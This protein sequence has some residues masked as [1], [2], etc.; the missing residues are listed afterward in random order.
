MKRGNKRK[1]LYYRLCQNGISVRIYLSFVF[2]L[3][4]TLVMT[5]LIFNQMYQKNYINSHTELLTK[6]GKK[7]A[8]RVAKF[9]ANDKLTQYEKYNVYLDELEKADKTDV[10]IV[11]N[12]EA[13]Q[14]LSEDY[15]NADMTDGTLTE[16]M[17]RVLEGAFQGEITASSSYDKAY[18]MMILRVAIPICDPNTAQVIG[19]VMMVS[20]V[21]KQTMGLD[22]GKYLIT[23]SAL[24][25]ILISF[26]IA[27]A[28]TR[29]LSIPLNKIHRDITKLA[30][31]EYT[32]IVTYSNSRQLAVLEEKLNELSSKLAK[33]EIEQENLEQARKDFFAN[34][35]HELRTP[36]TVIRGY[37]ESLHD[38]VVVEPERVDGLYQRILTECKGMERLVE[39]LFVLSKMQNPDFEIAK[40]PV[41]LRQV[42]VDVVRS[43]RILGQE[44]HL[45]LELD[46]PEKDPCMMFGDY[47]RL[48]QMFLIIVDNAVKF[49]PEDGRIRIHLQ[50]KEGT[51]EISIQDEGIGIAKEQ[52]PY[53]FEKFYKSKMRQNEKGT[54]LGLMIAKQIALRHEGDIW[55][56]SEAGKGSTFYFVFAEMTSM[57]EY[58]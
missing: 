58:E 1:G 7:V 26:V 2:V 37:T 5:G 10:W 31:G 43:G 34:V 54:G 9:Y 8:K 50:K 56:E 27:L 32:E 36:I 42:F 39:D 28:F 38:G 33:A 16:E 29:Y 44:K 14:P 51:L 13:A 12:H 20:M 18:G 6:Q 41:S 19:G 17:N 15:T 22:E 48:R 46:L 45:E 24:A 35:S 40:E 52:Q 47:D 49:S 23:M 4:V 3:I 55:V 11:S 57:E 30:S 21:D 53:I 25:A